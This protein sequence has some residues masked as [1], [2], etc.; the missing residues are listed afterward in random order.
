MRILLINAPSRF[1]PDFP[2]PSIIR[3]KGKDMPL[4]LLYLAASLRAAGFLDL[5]ILDAHTKGLDPNQTAAEIIN[6]APD[7]LCATA[8]SFSS[9]DLWLCFQQIRKALPDCT[10]AVG[11]P[12]V[13]A[14]PKESLVGFDADFICA[15]YGERAAVQ[16]AQAV[17]EKRLPENEPG[18]GYFSDDVFVFTEP[19]AGS[20]D[21]D[22]LPFPDRT[23]VRADDYASWVVDRP[24]PTTA[25][26]TSRG[27]PL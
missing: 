25:M 8:Y 17:Q 11:G 15:G 10:I 9:F 7:L 12:A 21:L 27:L 22:L 18:I 13:T 20:Q 26:M 23:L 16:I 4:G 3:D 1:G 24:A 5:K 19:K 2:I 6:I 14:Y